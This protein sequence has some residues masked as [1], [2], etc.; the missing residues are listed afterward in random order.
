MRKVQQGPGEDIR[1]LILEPGRPAD[2]SRKQEVDPVRCKLV[3]T[4]LPSL[5]DSS[6]GDTIPYEALSYFWGLGPDN[7]STWPA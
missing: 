2:P 6:P 4:V 1:V 5:G 7:V 3:S